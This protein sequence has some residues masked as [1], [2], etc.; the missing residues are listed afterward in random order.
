MVYMKKPKH[1]AGKIARQI[2]SQRFE[3]KKRKKKR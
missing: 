2:M 1:S 3:K